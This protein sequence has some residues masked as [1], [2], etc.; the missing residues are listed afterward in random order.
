MRSRIFVL[1]LL[2]AAA[3]AFQ[4]GVAQAQTSAAAIEDCMRELRSGLKAGQKMTEQQ[5]MLAEA[6]CRA[7]AEQTQPV[8]K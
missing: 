1:A 8:K 4:A 2:I 6:Q 5:R 7:R 3:A